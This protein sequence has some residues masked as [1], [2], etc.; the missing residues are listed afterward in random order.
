MFVYIE[1]PQQPMTCEY[2]LFESMYCSYHIPLSPNSFH[3]T[4]GIPDATFEYIIMSMDVYTY[5]RSRKFFSKYRALHTIMTIAMTD[6]ELPKANR[7]PLQGRTPKW[8]VDRYLQVNLQRFK[9]ERSDPSHTPRHIHRSEVYAVFGRHAKWLSETIK[10]N[11][12]LNYEAWQQFSLE[13]ASRRRK[14]VKPEEVDQLQD[15]AEFER[16]WDEPAA[17]D[18]PPEQDDHEELE[19][20]S[21]HESD[22]PVKAS[23]DHHLFD[24]DVLKSIPGFQKPFDFTRIP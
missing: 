3:R 17:P 1:L 15:W 21:T 24:G 12:L 11:K 13:M 7:T 23:K 14:G 2:S 10:K 9:E 20:V 19:Y 8:L 4:P 6:N 22:A 18:S 5:S 16:I